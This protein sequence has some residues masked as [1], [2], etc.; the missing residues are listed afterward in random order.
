MKSS[1]DN[2]VLSNINSALNW[3]IEV[4]MVAY[5]SV[6]CTWPL[7][8]ELAIFPASQEWIT[9]QEGRGVAPGFN[10]LN[11][12]DRSD[13]PQVYGVKEYTRFILKVET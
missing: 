1:P 8:Y 13:H 4:H 11:V 7:L 9:H 10:V 5:Q 3:I 2:F 6:P 12:F